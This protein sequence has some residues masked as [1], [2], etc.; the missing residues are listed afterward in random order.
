M[1][2]PRVKV[3]E[4]LPYQ[5]GF[6][7]MTFFLFIVIATYQVVWEAKHKTDSI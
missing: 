2:K 7:N 4:L 1:Q 5:G 6:K 3:L